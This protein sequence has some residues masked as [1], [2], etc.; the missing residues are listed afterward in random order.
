LPPYAYVFGFAFLSDGWLGHA[1]ALACRWRKGA[2]GGGSGGHGPHCPPIHPKKPHAFPAP[3][4]P[5][6]PRV[7]WHTSVRAQPL[8]ETEGTP[9]AMAFKS[10][11]ARGAVAVALAMVV[12]GA[13]LPATTAVLPPTHKAAL[14]ELY[15]STNGPY[16]LR[17]ELWKTYAVVKNDPCVARWLGVTCDIT[18]SRLTYVVCWLAP[19]GLVKGGRPPSAPHHTLLPAPCPPAPC[20][21]QRIPLSLETHICTWWWGGGRLERGRHGA[22][23]APTAMPLPRWLLLKAPHSPPR[24]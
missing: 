3:P 1:D 14:V 15:L 5:P 11:P 6:H 23:N 19:L 17:N 12:V 18:N 7:C 13:L 24:P 4:L 20:P 8:P 10:K 2:G 9:D 22:G 21:S 16:W